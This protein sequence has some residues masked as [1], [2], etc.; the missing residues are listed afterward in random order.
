MVSAETK[1]SEKLVRGPRKRAKSQTKKRFI[2]A[3]L[4]ATQLA[5]ASFQNKPCQ[6]TVFT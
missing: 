3:T 4:I 5:R 1:A 6:R 2:A